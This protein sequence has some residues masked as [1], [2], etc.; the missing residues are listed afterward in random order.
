MRAILWLLV[1]L[2]V[3]RHH[4]VIVGADDEDDKDKGIVDPAQQLVLIVN[5]NPYCYSTTGPTQQELLC[6]LKEGMDGSGM[7]NWKC[8]G[9]EDNVCGGWHGVDCSEDKIV[10]SVN[11]WGGRL[12]GTLS[13]HI[14]QLT[15]LTFFAMN[16]N[17]IKGTIPTELG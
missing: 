3:F 12:G 2:S 17:R 4:D 1:I 6:L 11:M 10:V 7:W 8:D 9:T 13:T 15:T 14:G 5:T 16:V